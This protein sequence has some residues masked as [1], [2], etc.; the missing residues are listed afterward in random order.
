MPD[1]VSDSDDGGCDGPIVTYWGT[2]G[3]Y[4]R[5]QDVI[6]SSGNENEDMPNLVSEDLPDLV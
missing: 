5:V 3:L 2:L 4:Q 1:L 6:G